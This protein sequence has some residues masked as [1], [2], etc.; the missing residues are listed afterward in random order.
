M[1]SVIGLF[2]QT[3]CPHITICHLPNCVFSHETAKRK[4][5]DLHPVVTDADQKLRPH[6]KPRLREISSGTDSE[7]S[8]TSLSTSLERRHGKKRRLS[9]DAQFEGRQESPP[10]TLDDLVRA[11]PV[12]KS[13]AEGGNKR[14][15]SDCRLFSKA[16]EISPPPLRNA[17][18]QAKKEAPG[19][20]P[21]R[22][23][24]SLPRA[25][26]PIPESLNPRMLP[27]PPASH[28]VRLKMATVLH[29]QILRLNDEV[30]RSQDPSKGALAMSRQESVT[31]ALNE[32][33][34]IARG[35]PQVYANIIKLRIVALKK[36]KLDDW[37]KERLKHIESLFPMVSTSVKQP[38]AK[39]ET[40]LSTQEEIALLP[41]LVAQ[42]EYLPK[43]GYVTT[44]PTEKEITQAKDGVEASQGWEQCDRCKSRFQVFPGRRAE[45]GALTTGGKCL[46]HHGKPFRSSHGANQGHR[47]SMYSC[48]NQPLATSGCTEAE[49]HVFKVSDAKR[50]AFVMPFKKTPAN[51]EQTTYRAICLDCEM[52]YTTLGMELIRLTAT[53]W[54]TGKDVLDLLVRPLGEVLDLNSRFSGIRPNDF[55]IAK[56]YQD[57]CV[58]RDALG[59]SNEAMEWP[60]TVDSP[61]VARDLLF[62]CLTPKTPLIGHALENDLNATRIIHPTIVDTVVCFPHPRGGLP[63][64][65]GLKTLM[66]TV[67]DR[68]IQTGGAHGHDAREDANA[69]G[70]LVRYKVGE[71]W[72]SLKREGWTVSKGEFFPPPV[73]HA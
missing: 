20:D 53:S 49:S 3:L 73:P 32:E 11:I 37:K 42:Q 29:E 18:P 2:K 19:S 41:R 9:I 68:D 16:K 15:A 71:T 23:S 35:N 17:G 40:G 55:S 43:H 69:A 21:Q 39:L 45:D 38:S 66:K 12:P 57:D 52:G 28:A 7:D 46:Y 64:R 72:K 1:F 10:V 47:E 56:P 48:C 4:S 14:S 62:R 61:V 33:E 70:D 34:E 27:K 50:L 44:A 8:V 13:S 63:L 36:M 31:Q 67:L 60:R 6:K 24:D 22:P 25:R 5:S 26:V 54:P 59:E 51:L 58:T 65:Y 30:K